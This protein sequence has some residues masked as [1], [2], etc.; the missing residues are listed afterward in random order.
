MR[1]HQIFPLIVIVLAFLGGIGLFTSGMR[2]FAHDESRCGTSAC[3]GPFMGITDAN[4]PYDLRFIDEMVMH[5]QGAIMSSEMMI[6]DSERPELRD[7]AQRIQE[8]Q[9]RQI[10]QMLAWRA[11]WYPD[12]PTPAMD[13]NPMGQMM[14]GTGMMGGM[15]GG[16]MT[17]RM[18]LRMMIPHHQLAIEMG[19]DALVN[20]DHEELKTLAQEIIDGQSAEITEM[21]R[22]LSDWYDEESTRDAAAAMRTMMGGC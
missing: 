1:K 15:M 17:D 7:L 18:F 9:Q 2:T 16:E 14:D 5:H 3:D 6:A 13:S 19:E 22:Y 12:A 10:D 4:A 21:E 8:D 11:E 20:A